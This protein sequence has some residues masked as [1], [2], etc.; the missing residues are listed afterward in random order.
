MTK[1]LGV[2]LLFG[3]ALATFTSAALAQERQEIATGRAEVQSDR[4]AIVAANLPLTDD[5]AK[6]FWPMYREYRGEMEKVGDRLVELVLNYA[7]S[8]DTL[9]DAQATSMLDE[10]LAIQKDENKIRTAW[11]PKFRKGLPSKTV[12]RFY[13]IENKLDAILRFDAAAQI[14][15]VKSE[16]K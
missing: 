12:T 8:S 14:P 10:F 4:Q 9:T 15:M 11:V 1:K 5:Q 7:K 2:S 6:V 16:T 13:Q 3:L